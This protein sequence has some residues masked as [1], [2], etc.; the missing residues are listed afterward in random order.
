MIVNTNPDDG[1]DNKKKL[2]VLSKIDELK[3]IANNHYLMRKFDEAIKI[4]EE[5]MDIAEQAE[6]YSVVREEGEYIATL[7]KQA[8]DEDNF[9]VIRDDFENLEK[10]FDDLVEKGGIGEAHDLVQ[11]FKQYYEKKIDLNSFAN[12]RDFL[13]RDSSMW[14]G[15][16]TKEQNIIKQLEPLEIQFTSYINT[17]NLTLAGEA[18]EKAK[19]LLKE[20]TNIKIIKRWETS[21]AMFLELRKKD[22]QDENIEKTLK[23]VSKLTENY[24]FAKAK[25]ILD[26]KIEYLESEGL[27]EY[28]QIIKTKKKYIQNAEKK[29]LKLEDDLKALEVL[30]NE[31]IERNEYKQAIN[32][33]NQIIKISRF[34]GKIK[35]I[36]RF[37]E[38]INLIE[39][40]I[41]LGAK[42]EKIVHKVKD[43]NFKALELFKK[44]DYDNSLLIFKEIM[45]LIKT[46]IPE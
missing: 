21:E 23:E 18:L 25:K 15:F 27:T 22:V 36:E 16:S 10:K 1:G 5:I 6:L 43:L 42:T 8:K 20:L 17:N 37:S 39:D 34:I 29:F 19:I 4:A 28:N 38:Y 7:Y 24:E 11:T 41:K 40:K 30:I 9:I 45:K 12:V 31:N 3:V 13:S 26:L 2:E 44:E 14:N 35:G 32:N 33:I 46:E